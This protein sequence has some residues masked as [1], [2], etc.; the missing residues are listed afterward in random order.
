MQNT[1]GNIWNYY[2]VYAERDRHRVYI[3]Y[4]TMLQLI[5]QVVFFFGTV[6]DT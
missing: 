6:T 3:G 5:V 4:I 2:L 1:F